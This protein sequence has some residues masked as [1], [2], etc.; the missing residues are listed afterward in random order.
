MARYLGDYLDNLG[1]ETK[2][3]R[4]SNGR[5]NII[6]ILKGDGSGKNLMINGHLDTVGIGGMQNPFS[7]EIRDGK[8]Y[9]RGA[10]DMKGG[11]VSSVAAIE[12]IIKSNI[13]LKGDVILCFVTDEEYGSRGTEIS[14]EEYSADAGI[15]CEPTDSE[16]IIAHK[17]FIWVEIAVYGMAA[18]GSMPEKGVDAIINAGKVL[19]ELDNLQNGSWKK[20]IHPLLGNP[21]LHASTIDGG[22]GISTYPDKCTFS[23]EIRTLPNQTDK[24]VENDLLAIFDK[25]SMNDHQFKAELKVTLS[26]QPLEVQTDETVVRLLAKAREEVISKAPTFTGVPYWTD[27]ALLFEKGIPTV[28]IGPD[29]DG[30]HAAVEYVEIESVENIAKI[31]EK[32]VLEFCGMT[33]IS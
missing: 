28:L 15:I 11:I 13:K 3:Q 24:M 2:Y 10:F 16:I 31:L 4:H 19:V 17:G 27:A 12:S 23:I 14:L 5:E 25:L 8:I 29:G 1:L 32:V 6:A 30:A 26:R 20:L 7:A 22:L 9:G 18:H 21:T 33:E